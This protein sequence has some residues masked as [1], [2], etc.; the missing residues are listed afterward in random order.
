MVEDRRVVFKDR[1]EA[2]QILAHEVERFIG[3]PGTVF[4]VAKGGVPVG[5]M[6]ARTLKLRV[7]VIFP[8]KIPVPGRQ[9]VGLG[10][11]M[12]DGTTVLNNVL[13]SRLNFKPHQIDTLKED[14]IN[15]I[16]R[17]TTKL[18][19]YAPYPDIGGKTVFLVDDGLASGYTML[20]AVRWVS[21][22]YPRRIVVAVPVS[23][24]AAYDL[25]RNEVDEFIALRICSAPDFA[26]AKFYE[27]WF[28]SEE[29]ALEC[30]GITAEEGLL[31]C[32]TTPQ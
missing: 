27:E 9:Q 22:S 14:V 28:I 19:G 6:L 7:D 18:R 13:I 5:C 31:S 4:S 20:A 25:L 12:Q 10:A 1:C 26:V 17:E 23:S 16:K 8:R 30:L 21:R 32:L 29:R 15:Q 2:G 24:F 3:E 11:M